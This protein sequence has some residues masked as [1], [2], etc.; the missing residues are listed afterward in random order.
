M[1]NEGGKRVVVNQ[2]YV[3]DESGFD[4]GLFAEVY[5]ILAKAQAIVAVRNGFQWR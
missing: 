1:E 5:P 3:V 4:A 2:P